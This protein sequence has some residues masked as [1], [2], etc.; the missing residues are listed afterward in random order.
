MQFFCGWFE[1]QAGCCS[2]AEQYVLS[3]MR[4]DLS[5]WHGMVMCILSNGLLTEFLVAGKESV[6]TIQKRLKMCAVA[7]LVIKA[8]LVGRLHKMQ[9][10]RKARWS[11]VKRIVLPGWH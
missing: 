3:H 11:S 10:V 6:T 7:V 1:Y 9:V 4:R 8:L 2:T 5:K